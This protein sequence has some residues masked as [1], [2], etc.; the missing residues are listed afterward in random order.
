MN[1]LNL[2]TVLKKIKLAES[3]I[4]TLL[5][6]FVILVV[7]ILIYKY[8]QGA[9][10]NQDVKVGLVEKKEEI[11]EGQLPK[12]TEIKPEIK[13]YTV[14]K[15]ESLWKIAL[16]FYG[17][18]YNWVD[19]A[20]ANKISNPDSISPSIQLDLPDAKIRLANKGVVTE[21]TIGKA[22]TENQY[23]V[24]KGDTLWNISVRAYGDGFRWIEIAK[25]NKLV[26]PGLI[27][28]GNILVIPR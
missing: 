12:V 8:F 19:I 24:V 6:I 22:I 21:K 7:G 26:H 3:T 23:Q 27:H 18:G 9:S 25:A 11:E 10:L 1:E 17:S 4:S 5:G 13:T 20:K 2:K 14:Q 16:K 28:P 15:G